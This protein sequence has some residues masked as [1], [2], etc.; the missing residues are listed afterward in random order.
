MDAI[1]VLCLIV[2]L[3]QASLEPTVQQLGSNEFR[4]REKAHKWL[5]NQLKVPW[6]E[7]LQAGLRKKPRQDLE[8]EM[9]VRLLTR[10]LDELC[11]EYGHFP[12]I[13]ALPKDFKNR[14]EIHIVFWG[15]AKEEIP[16]YGQ[17]YEQHRYATF[18][19]LNNLRTK[20]AWVSS[21]HRI[22]RLMIV[23]EMHWKQYG[24]YP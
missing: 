23:N 6:K 21:I 4:V 22:Q 7:F 11:T 2:G 14:E 17:D 10:E 9:R 18:L 3:H 20:G 15:K 12:W 16:Y 19:F 1:N 5:E 8:T 13:C 24:R